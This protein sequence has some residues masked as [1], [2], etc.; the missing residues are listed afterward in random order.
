M[1]P[2]GVQQINL[3]LPELRPRRDLVTA[4]R[5]AQVTGVILLVMVLVSLVNVWIRA[6][7][8]GDLEEMQAMVVAQLNRTDTIE[9]EVAGRATD[10]ALI[11]EMD[12]RELRLAQSRELYDFMSNTNLGNLSGYSSHLKDLS[13]ASF[14]G[15][16][17]TEF[18]ITG[19]ATF[20]SLKGNAQ[21]AAMLPDYVSRLSMGESVIRN[22]RFSRLLSTRS[23]TS[24]E[25]MYEFVLETSQ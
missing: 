3:Y 23:T 10:Q 2:G 1:I 7:L 11:R 17:L 5:L 13:R 12:T 22:K 4:V 20:V 6:G 25:E 9:R 18:S 14:P 21:L 8:R 16:W 15:L 24:V 19:D